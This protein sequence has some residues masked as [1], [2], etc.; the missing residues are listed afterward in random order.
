MK[1][2]VIAAIM[3]LLKYSPTLTTNIH[4]DL[5]KV[6]C[7]SKTVKQQEPKLTGMLAVIN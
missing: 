3:V 6:Y 1:L 5:E 2:T 4:F 7:S